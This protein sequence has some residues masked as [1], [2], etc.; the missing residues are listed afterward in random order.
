MVT[1]LNKTLEQLDRKNLSEQTDSRLIATIH[2]LRKKPLKDF[3]VED[4]RLLIGQNLNLDNLIP[5][6]L[7]RL[8]ENI[9]AEGDLFPGDLL[10]SVLDSD[11]N[12]WTKNK[13]YWRTVKQYY[14]DSGHIIESDNTYRQI[15]KSFERF[16]KI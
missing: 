10:K 5:L 13:N 3:S 6:A 14:I 7:D 9:L 4:L 15:R 8:K 12:F 11:S 2:Q 1:D 16:E